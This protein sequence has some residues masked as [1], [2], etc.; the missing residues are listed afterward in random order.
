MLVWTTT[1]S[2]MGIRLNHTATLLLDG[3]VL[4]AGGI[5]SVH[6]SGLDLLASAELYD[7]SR[8]SWTA[9]A[10]MSEARSNHT[11][12]M[13]PDGKVLVT[14]GFNLNSR[15]GVLTSAELYEWSTGVWT[16]AGN[17]IGG[18]AAHSATLLPDG[19]VLV[20]GGS[21]TAGTEAVASAELYD[22]VNGTW[23]ATGHME[24]PR[25]GHT[26]TLLLDGKVLVAGGETSA[27]VL[28]SA[29]L[30]DP[31]SGTWTAA[32]QMDELRAAHTA[33]LLSDGRVLVAGGYLSSR[34]A[35]ASAEVFDPGRGSWSAAAPIIDARSF[36][37]A[38][39]LPDGNV[40]VAGGRSSWIGNAALASAELYHPDSGTWTATA[41]MIEPRFGHIATLL[42]EGK[43]LLAGG[44]G[45]G[46]YDA[47]ASAEEYAPSDDP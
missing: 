10:E 11:A 3:N 12:T 5:D 27:G 34:E 47:L 15:R 43:V 44:G 19:R 16:S 22:P 14:G 13:L 40:L 4:V 33:T 41:T 28:A 35:V 1:A 8:G 38:T 32:G 2:M 26:A 24:E 6:I 37:T 46:Y 30:Y 21:S 29:E 45:T 36:Q 7:P 25:F 18:R 31:T 17:M 23:T 39:L 9:A 20:A 42:P